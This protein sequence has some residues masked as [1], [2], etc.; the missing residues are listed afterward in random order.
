MIIY[1]S[2]DFFLNLRYGKKKVVVFF[3]RETERKDEEMQRLLRKKTF[4]FFF[5][6]LHE[7]HQKMHTSIHY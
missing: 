2:V 4:E 5:P 7:M 3:S 1:L 6:L